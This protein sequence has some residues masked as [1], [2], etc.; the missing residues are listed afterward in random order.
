MPK[1]TDN[2]YD[3]LFPKMSEKEKAKR[4]TE[5]TVLPESV[6]APL[7]KGDII[8]TV[9]Y[10]FEGEILAQENVLAET[11]VPAIG[12]YGMFGKILKGI[13]LGER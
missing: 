10:E 3:K 9:I 6:K 11:E 5:R 7:K 13:C 2:K 8:G 4:I 1:K 12:L